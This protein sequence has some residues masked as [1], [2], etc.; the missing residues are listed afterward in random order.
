MIYRAM[1]LATGI[2]LAHSNIN[3]EPADPVKY[4]PLAL[5]PYPG[6]GKIGEPQDGIITSLDNIK[7]NSDQTAELQ[8]EE[9]VCISPLDPDIAVA[10]WRDFRFGYRRVGVGRTTD[11]GRTWTDALIT[12]YPPYDWQSDPVLWVDREGTFYVSTLDLYSGDGP[13]GIA[14]Y[15]STDNGATWTDPTWAVQEQ[16]DYFED[17]QWFGMDQTGGPGDGNIYCVWDRFAADYS[18][19][20]IVCV[21]ST[22]G[23]VTFSEPV[24]VSAYGPSYVQWPTVTCD[25]QSNVYVAWY[26]HRSLAR[27][28]MAISDDFGQSFSTPF[29]AT[30]LESAFHELNGDILCFPYP[31]MACDVNPQSDNLGRLYIIYPDGGFDWDIWCVY[32]DDGGESWSD[33]VRVNDDPFEN[34]CDQ[35][36][37]WL[38]IDEAGVIHVCFLDRRDDP[39]NMLYNLYYTRSTDG[40]ETWEENHR[41]STV[42]SD[43]NHAALAGLLGEYIGISAWQGE[44]QMVWTDI[45][46][47]N[48]DAY[49]AR[50]RAAFLAGDANNTEELLSS[51]VDY[52]VG[53]FE[54]VNQVPDP[55]IWRADANGDC[56]IDAADVTYLVAYFRGIGLAPVDGDC[57]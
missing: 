9:V 14:I 46:N 31:A 18:A 6:P 13:S 50:I 25:P 55:P 7:I 56:L 20:G 10:V 57:N 29:T 1:I 52:L 54:G 53:Y 28:S 19:T 40:G 23:G 41:I 34:G 45:R 30:F 12:P 26:D 42:S 5:V 47:L 16:Y 24:N 4:Y 44:V 11:G 8:N 36:H 2:L 27:I 48:Q 39:A 51:D 33:R 22:D 32:S 21:N 15:K 49:S 3:S 37:P 17:K 35:F 43:P 38:A